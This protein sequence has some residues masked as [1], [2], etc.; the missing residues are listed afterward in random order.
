MNFIDLNDIKIPEYICSKKD[1]EDNYSNWLWETF[2][3]LSHGVHPDFLIESIKEYLT[4]LEVKNIF[5]KLEQSIYENGECY[6]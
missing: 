3:L 6:E 4:N 2:Q 5:F 1:C